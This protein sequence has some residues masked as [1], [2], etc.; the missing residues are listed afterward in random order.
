MPCFQTAWRQQL[1]LT[2]VVQQMKTVNKVGFNQDSPQALLSNGLAAAIA[3]D[4]GGA[5]GAGA[6]AEGGAARLAGWRSKAH[7]LPHLGPELNW[8]Q[9]A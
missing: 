5:A 8:E 7:G 1:H 3:L 6:A 9:K 4:Q 2:R